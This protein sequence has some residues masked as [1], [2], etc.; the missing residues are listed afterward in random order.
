LS[1]PVAFKFI[2]DL[3]VEIKA[4]IG[5]INDALCDVSLAHS[6]SV[7]Q[8]VMEDRYYYLRH[9]NFTKKKGTKKDSDNDEE[10]FVQDDLVEEDLVEEDDKNTVVKP[11]TVVHNLDSNEDAELQRAIQASLGNQ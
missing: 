7:P 10:V 2:L 4:L 9:K 6:Y 5:M 8:I 3:D 11:Y 1:V